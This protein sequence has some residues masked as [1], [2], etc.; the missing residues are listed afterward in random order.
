MLINN[1]FMKKYTIPIVLLIIGG[2]VILFGAFLKIQSQ[3]SK[4]ILAVGL[5]LELASILLFMIK[6][7]KSK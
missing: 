5:I 3:G 7:F 2:I 4:T 6:Y 1:L